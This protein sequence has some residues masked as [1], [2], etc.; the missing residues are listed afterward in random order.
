MSFFIFNG[1]NS[2]ELGITISEYP[3]TPFPERVI[4]TYQVPGRSGDL[5]FDTGSYSNV[6][7]SYEA[8]YK[9]PKGFTSYD[10]IRYISKWLLFPTGYQV[11]EDSC[12]PDVFRLAMYTGPADIGTFFAKYGKATLEFNCM[13]QK[14]LKEGQYPIQIESGMHLYNNWQTAAPLIEIQGTGSGVLSIGDSIVNF[15]S[16]PETGL[17]LDSDTQNIYSGTQNLNNT[18]QISNDFPMLPP[19]KTG[20]TFSGGITAVSI[21]PRWW[22]L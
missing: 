19:G 17:T 5:V 11:L 10:F 3:E 6:T 15:S 22:T 21:I 14:Y 13:P 7:Q 4:E 1:T 20:I 8:W 12:F 18:A 9:A 16:I 2:T